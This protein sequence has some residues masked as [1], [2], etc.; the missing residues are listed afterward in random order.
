MILG[1]EKSNNKY[2]FD[3]MFSAGL[4]QPVRMDSNCKVLPHKIYTKHSEVHFC[5]SF[6]KQ[7]SCICV[8]SFPI[9]FCF[10]FLTWCLHLVINLSNS[11]LYAIFCFDAFK[12]FLLSSVR[13]RCLN[14]CPHFIFWSFF[15]F[16]STLSLLVVAFIHLS[17]LVHVHV[18][19]SYVKI[20]GVNEDVKTSKIKLPQNDQFQSTIQCKG[21]ANL[22]VSLTF[23]GSPLPLIMLTLHL[24]GLWDL[25]WTR[26]LAAHH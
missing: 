9:L 21:W 3:L 16:L 22:L 24:Q 7:S 5:L 15:S 2:G 20:S 8:H 11:H 6:H 10:S 17:L 1:H 26:E 4:V 13:N 18:S 23:P 25:F 12:G 14:Q 19:T